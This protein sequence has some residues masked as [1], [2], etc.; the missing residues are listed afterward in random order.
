MSYSGR[1]SRFY[2]VFLKRLIDIVVSLL[3]IVV[4]F[5]PGVILAIVIALQSKGAPFYSQERLGLGGK[6]FK[7]LKF[8]SMVADANDVEKYFTPEQLREWQTERKLD[9]DPR[10]TGIGRF[11]RKTSLDESRSSSTFLR[12]TCPSWGRAP[13]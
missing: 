12:V 5:I 7:L 1:G 11:L 10:V 4:A 2:L 9:N 8:R 6:H 3:V 13:L